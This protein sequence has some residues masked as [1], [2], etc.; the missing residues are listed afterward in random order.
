MIMWSVDGFDKNSLVIEAHGWKALY[1]CMP[2]EDSD[3][4]WDKD[5]NEDR[6][7]HLCHQQKSRVMHQNILAQERVIELKD[8]ITNRKAGNNSHNLINNRWYVALRN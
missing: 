1:K 7:V 3:T 4:D 6:P 2:D 5:E 8:D